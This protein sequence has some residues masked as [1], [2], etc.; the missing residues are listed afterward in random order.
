[1]RL[2]GQEADKAEKSRETPGRALLALVLTRSV[3]RPDA[4]TRC[5]APPYY[6]RPALLT[7]PCHR[8]LLFACS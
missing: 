3:A 7:L 4:L 1:M 6:R 8:A 5:G 2:E